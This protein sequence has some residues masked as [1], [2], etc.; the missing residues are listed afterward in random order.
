MLLLSLLTL[1][2]AQDAPRARPSAPPPEAA[3]PPASEPA[4]LAEGELPPLVKDPAIFEFVQAPY[5]PE[6]EAAGIERTV[7]LVLEIDATG[8]VTKVDV[9]TPAA[10]GSVE[11]LFDAAAV[12]AARQFTF[13]PAED[14]TG[15]VPVAVEFDYGFQ[16]AP[17]PV[18]VEEAAPALAI[19]GTLR[20]MAT[21]VPI[22]G[23][24]VQ[25][26]R[27]D[28]VV[29]SAT[30]D[31]EGKFAIAG[32]EPGE[33]TLVAFT[34]EHQKDVIKL[35][36]TPGEVAEVSAWLRRLTYRGAGVV[37]IY[38]QDRPPEVTRRTITMAEVR[39]V[40]GTF[41][42]P[43]RVIQS[44]PGAA[45]APFLTGLLILRGANPEDSNVYVDGVEVP[46]VYHLGGLRSIINPDLVSSVDYLPGTY[47]AR[48]GRSTGG[49]IDVRTTSE[50]P[51]QTKLAWRSDV[52]DTGLFA[53]GRLGKKGK[54][55]VGFSIGARRS[56][57]DALL[58]IVATNLEFYSAPRWM[59]Y[60]VKLEALDVGDNELSAFLFGFQ[61]DLI[62]RTN[63]DA[64]DQV[65]VH[66]STHRLV[67]RW[68]RPLSE[69]VKFHLQPAFGIDGARVGFGS[70]IGSE[71]DSMTIDLRGELR[72]TPSE[73]LSV[74]VGLDSELYRADLKLYIAGVPVDGQ[75]PL[76][77]EEPIEIDGGRW[78]AYPDPYVEAQ[79]RP[80]ADRDRL[81]FVGGL[82]VDGIIRTPPDNPGEPV[83]FAPD[84]RFATR[85]EVFKGG[86][87]KAGTGLYH[88]P[89]QN[90]QLIGDAFFERAWGSEL[91]WEQKIGE[92]VTADATGFYRWM[93]PLALGF[94]LP[95]EG[96]GLP[97]EGEGN[98]VGRA[99]GLEVMVRHARVD[100][101]FGWIS[102][103]LSKSERNDTPGDK[104]GWYDYD[105]DQTHILT[106]VAGYRL[107]LDFE[108]SGRVQ[109]VTGNPYT[110]YD[111][112]GLYLMDEGSY[113]GFP[114]ADTNSER[115]APFYGVDL[116]V[117]RL[118][119]F[120][121]WQLE[122]FA[123]VLNVVHG[124][125]PEFQLYN[126][127]YTESAVIS[128]LPI[129]PSI[130]FQL[131]MN[132]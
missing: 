87:V 125:N 27:G 29:A 122:L 59:D 57:V 96:G 112:S 69:T 15:P 95:G 119:T 46:L 30:T 22:P 78:N 109:Y 120:K 21:R 110:P 17:E 81:L 36:V 39:R 28:V 11:A 67:L 44:L 124:E 74:A 16:L 48:Y 76:S 66:Y 37:G 90:A 3:A 63:K 41:G 25:V 9:V 72:W 130:G 8:A 12:E 116:R 118:F 2:A 60:Q 23:A 93:D 34:T 58:G 51:E 83:Q 86:T 6:A 77:E 43:V 38:E 52:L 99:Y 98:G 14:A 92:A 97:G 113:L 94:G 4:A 89:P 88:Q 106:A 24:A 5:P 31:A 68:A 13:S 61:D 84:P 132:L 103:T 102:Y 128:G 111:G 123:D 26:K 75:D 33:V 62:I 55:K 71:L 45:R 49:V 42:D 32:V 20:E 126:Y 121:H 47:S 104:E 127:D 85:F 7:R 131:E 10:P 101:F 80:L 115:L 35:T 107:P 50:Y 91:G 100:K 73:A 117:S 64:E 82:R 129:V 18:P 65:G 19:E 79:V 108:V 1:A 56:Y 70:E 40:P 105:F 53:T 114:G 54:E